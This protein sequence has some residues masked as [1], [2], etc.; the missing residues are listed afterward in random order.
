M[1]AGLNDDRQMLLMIVVDDYNSLVLDNL[2][3]CHVYILSS[4]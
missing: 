3:L 2:S 4:R 1:V